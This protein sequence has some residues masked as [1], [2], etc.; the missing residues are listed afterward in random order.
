MHH[1]GDAPTGC[2]G[3][4]G[5]STPRCLCHRGSFFG[6]ESYDSQVKAS[7]GCHWGVAGFETLQLP[8]FPSFGS[9]Q[10][11]WVATPR[12]R[13]AFNEELMSWFWVWI[14]LQNAKIIPNSK[15][16]W[17]IS[18]GTVFSM[19]VQLLKSLDTAHLIYRK[20]FPS[21]LKYVPVY[22]KNFMTL[23]L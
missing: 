1:N 6:V 4:G 21:S 13:Y 14:T 20:L 16:T 17:G 11:K 5:V 2:L 3:Q 23:S 10:D 8:S 18:N 22:Y 19:K 9:L 15:S 7:R 12:L